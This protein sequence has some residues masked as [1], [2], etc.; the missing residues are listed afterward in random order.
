MS[1]IVIYVSTAQRVFCSTCRQ[2][3]A[4]FTIESLM[5]ILGVQV[6]G[7]EIECD[8]DTM[9]PNRKCDRASAG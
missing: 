6:D 3:K 8:L 1:L 5:I 4:M 2:L 7:I 9:H